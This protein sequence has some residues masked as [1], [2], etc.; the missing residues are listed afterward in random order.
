MKL[1]SFALLPSVVIL[2]GAALGVLSTGCPA[3]GCPQCTLKKA[4]FTISPADGEIVDVVMHSEGVFT[5]HCGGERDPD[6]CT[7]SEKESLGALREGKQDPQP[8][9]WESDDDDRIT[10][11]VDV[12][13]RTDRGVVVQ[14]P[15]PAVSIVE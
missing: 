11:R 3:A 10:V 12:H 9:P 1:P 13:R 2:F 8:L 6:G 14:T 15:A 7:L 4:Q 5:K